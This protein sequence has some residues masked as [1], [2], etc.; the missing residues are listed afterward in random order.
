MAG[1][2]FFGWAAVLAEKVGSKYTDRQRCRSQLYEFME[3][4]SWF[5]LNRSP[6]SNREAVLYRKTQW[7]LS[8]EE[9]ALLEP[10]LCLWL[11]AYQ[12][13]NREKLALLAGHGMQL[14]PETTSAYM[15]FIRQEHWENRQPA[16][17]L[18][19]H[20]LASVN[21]ELKDCTAEEIEELAAQMDKEIPLATAQLFSRFLEYIGR[22]QRGT[23][24]L[25]QFSSRSKGTPGKNDAYTVREFSIMAYCVFHADA[26][27]E[28]HLVEKACS[29]AVYANLWAFVAMHF[30]CALRGT[31][32]ERL[33]LFELPCEGGELRRKFLAGNFEGTGSFVRDL[34]IRLRYKHLK[35]QK[36]AA[37]ENV[38]ELKVFVPQSLEEPLGIILAIAGSYC[39][40][41]KAGDGFLKISRKSTHIRKFFGDAFAKAAGGKDFSTRKANK[42]YLQGIGSIT[43]TDAPKGY[44]LAALARSHK[45]GLGTLPDTTEIYLRD[46]KF[47]GY[48]PEFIAREMFER[49]VFGFVPHLLLEACAGHEYTRL[50]VKAQTELVTRLGISISGI[51][52][53]IRLKERSLLEAK[54]VLSEV[55]TGRQDI[56]H[57]LQRIATGSA[58]GRQDGF[59]CVLSA[60]GYACRCPDR[61]G[62]LGCRYEIYTKAVLHLAA[63]E[64]TR[65]QT[66]Y[67]REKENW[68]YKMMLQQV[69]LPVIAEML[70]TMPRM[71]PRADMDSL[72]KF[73]EEGLSKYV[74]S[75]QSRP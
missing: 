20:L 7:L 33:P 40:D 47:S 42:A 3:A 60:A 70:E 50:P 45:R 53:L 46:A 61:S 4:N 17:Q 19:D 1:I 56:P 28:H 29:S 41:Q 44:M 75:G 10:R 72:V 49:G 38:P 2:D 21:R 59:L 16:W 39:T 48:T 66:L 34:Q 63:R 26:W 65:L 51:E 67:R 6:E 14:H 73:M 71:Y 35:P 23:R 8:P 31:D 43:G 55:I 15:E 22:T 68:R 57:I 24:W 52:E 32:I 62:C 5:E 27:E 58:A 74:S 11:S 9:A 36:T 69:I 13:D 64:Y 30:V 37:A 12:R 25:Y 18:L 54:R